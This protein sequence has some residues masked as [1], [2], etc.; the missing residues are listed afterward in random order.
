MSLSTRDM[1]CLGLLMLHYG[2]GTASSSFPTDLCGCTN[3]CLDPLAGLQSHGLEQPGP[4]D[5]WG[6]GMLWWTWDTL[7]YRGI[8]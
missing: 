1:A 5:R 6:Y 2:S 4:P 8:Q 3:L 7:D